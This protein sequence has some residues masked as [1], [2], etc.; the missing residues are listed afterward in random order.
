MLKGAKSQLFLMK[1][2]TI[3]ILFSFSII[4]IEIISKNHYKNILIMLLNDRKLYVKKQLKQSTK[5]IA[6]DNLIST[7]VRIKYDS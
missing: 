5:N 3:A 1:F 6:I 7:F 4:L 2:T